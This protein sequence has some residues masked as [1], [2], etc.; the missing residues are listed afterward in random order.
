VRR[1]EELDVGT[2]LHVVADGDGG[3]VEQDDA[4]VDEGPRPDTGLVA[5]V[6]AQG[7]ADLAAFTE[8]AEQLAEQGK[9]S[10]EVR[11]IAV[12]E[13]PGEVEGTQAVGG[14]LGVAGHVEV[15]GEHPLA[16]ATPVIRSC[17]CWLMARS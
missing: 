3:H 6:T 1:G 8:C 5:V 11:G 9:S 2:D 10:L 14:E 4:E 7:W 16:L 17:G 13:P 15:A 12:V